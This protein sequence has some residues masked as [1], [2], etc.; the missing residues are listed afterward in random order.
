MGFAWGT[1]D[2]EFRDSS[3]LIGNRIVELPGTPGRGLAAGHAAALARNLDVVFPR[4][5]ERCQFL[6]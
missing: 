3:L 5:R 4:N 1:A 2:F 6:K